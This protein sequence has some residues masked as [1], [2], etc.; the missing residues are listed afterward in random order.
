MRRRE[1]TRVGPPKAG[2][3]GTALGWL[4]QIV[5]RYLSVVLPE[6]PGFQ[7]IMFCLFLFAVVYEVCRV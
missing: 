1:V 3:K 7:K 2:Q 6:N 5:V 4:G